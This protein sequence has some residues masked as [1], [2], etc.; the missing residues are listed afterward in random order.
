MHVK[1]E[2]KLECI[3]SHLRNIGRTIKRGGGERSLSSFPSP[4]PRIN[5][6]RDDYITRSLEFCTINRGREQS[7]AVLEIC[8]QIGRLTFT[9]P[10]LFS[11]VFPG[12]FYAPQ[13]SD[14]AVKKGV[15]EGEGDNR[16]NARGNLTRPLVWRSDPIRFDRS[17]ISLPCIDRFDDEGWK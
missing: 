2:T 3:C 14:F 17:R 10:V 6:N 7:A 16:W 1:H 5:S 9:R 4:P 11:R 13:L 8:I 15:G 12:K